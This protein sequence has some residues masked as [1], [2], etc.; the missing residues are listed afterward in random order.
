MLVICLLADIESNL[1]NF[2]F[3]N[4]INVYICFMHLFK[5]IELT[6]FDSNINL[7]V[8]INTKETT[9]GPN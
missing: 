6:T 5:I 8:A 9:I 4:D 1:L 3:I 2:K 7:N